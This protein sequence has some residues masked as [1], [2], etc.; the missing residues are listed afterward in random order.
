MFDPK[1]IRRHSM[2]QSPEQ[3]LA[4]FNRT[5][6]YNL[7]YEYAICQAQTRLA[8]RSQNELEAGAVH[9]RELL[10]HAEEVEHDRLLEKMEA[11]EELIFQT[12]PSKFTA[13]FQEFDLDQQPDFPDASPSEYFA[14]L[15]M[16]YTLESLEMQ[17]QAD[18]WEAQIE[19]LDPIQRLRLPSLKRGAEERLLEAHSTITFIEGIE[20]EAIF[21]KKNAARANR[22]KNKAYQDLKRHIFEFVDLECIEFSNR[23]AAQVAYLQFKE[24]VDE[25]LNSD[26]PEHQIAKWIGTHRRESKKSK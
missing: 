24:L 23:K 6:P 16:V 2:K 15:A 4:K 17:L 22:A 13:L 25:T 12:D 18:S 5:I 14:I 20:F 19:K 11:G 7:D 9:L 3:I 26:D 10:L 1:I 8:H 21:R